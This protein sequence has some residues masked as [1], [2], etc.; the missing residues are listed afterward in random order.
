MHRTVKDL[1]AIADAKLDPTERE[2]VLKIIARLSHQ[3]EQWPDVDELMR[4]NLYFSYKS[5]E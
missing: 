1:Q 2:D 5:N 3:D 4:I